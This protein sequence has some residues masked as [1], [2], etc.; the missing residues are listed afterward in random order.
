MKVG[1][2][3]IVGVPA[4]Y[5]GFETLADNLIQYAESKRPE[6]ELSVY[7]SGPLGQREYRGATLRWIPIPANGLWSVFYDGLSLL[8]SGFRGDNVVL[9]LGVSG[10]VFLPLV[11]C[12]F[13]IKIVTNVDGIEWRREK[14]NPLAR[15]FLK[16]SE[17]IAV[18]WSSVVVSDNQAVSRYL[19]EQYG[20]ESVII[21]YGGD[22]ADCRC[23]NGSMVPPFNNY[24]LS[25]CRIEP[26]NNVELILR[27]A[28]KVP[29]VN[30]IFMGNW[31]TPHGKALHSR[32]SGLKNIRLLPPEYDAKKIYGLRVNALAYIHGHSAGG[33]NPSLVEMM[34]LGVPVFA[35]DCSF[36]RQTTENHAFFFETEQELMDLFTNIDED[37]LLSSSEAMKDLAMSKYTWAEVGRAY[38]DIFLSPY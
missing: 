30:L 21:P 32:W 22:H 38:C 23:P 17:R 1:I 35:F 34:Y 19:G 15:A 11:R 18:N 27:A 3:G 14:W 20:R 10:A 25:L 16:F 7:C 5:G 8:Y 9:V 28:S 33:T 37:T 4:S 31:S 12:L 13:R 2:V 29:S 36:N 24:F 6:L 26:E